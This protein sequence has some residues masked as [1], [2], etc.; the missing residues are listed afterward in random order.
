MVQESKLIKKKNN[1]IYFTILVVMLWCN[2]ILLDYVRGLLLRL[3]LISVA[4]DFI[5]PVIT[6]TCF[7]LSLRSIMSRLRSTDLLM[8]MAVLVVY[9]S[10]WALYPVNSYY[11]GKNM[12]SFLFGRLPLYF[13][14]VAFCSD[15]QEQRLNLLYK[16]SV[17]TIFVFTLYHLVVHPLD[18]AAMSTGDMNSS[19]NLLPHA[20]LVFYRMV[21]KPNPWNVSSFTLSCMLLF[22]LGSRGPVLCIIVFAAVVLFM[23]R[24]VKRPLMFCIIALVALMFIFIDDLLYTVLYWVYKLADTLG[25][26]TR[27]F[28]KYLTGNFTVSASRVEIQETVMGALNR[29]PVFGLGIYGDRSVSGGHYS[30]NI[31][32]EVLSQH[33]YFFGTILLI[34]IAVHVIRTYL[35]TGRRKDAVS[36]LVLMLLLGCNLK[37]MVSG[38]YLLEPFFYFLV[39]YCTA[40]LRIQKELK[41]E[42]I[43]NSAF[44]RVRRQV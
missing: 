34:A 23:G 6:G 43:C 27:V 3:P 31:L 29:N 10:H 26:S 44:L 7:L 2:S 4:A 28:D 36:T 41:R 5:L 33:G 12:W 20:C 18:D 25:L 13:V 35:F 19:Y 38:S 40:Q 8:V 11:Y 24:N 39:G 22:M 14:G 17:V 9:F 42:K 37:L 32:I 15:R 21:Q 16:T 1:E 30:H